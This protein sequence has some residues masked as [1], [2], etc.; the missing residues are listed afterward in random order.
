MFFKIFTVS[1]YA[2]IYNPS[3][4]PETTN[5][6]KVVAFEKEINDFKKLHPSASHTFLQSSAGDSSCCVQLTCI[7]TECAG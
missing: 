5:L 2:R 6:D 3:H 1:L 4:S 7:F